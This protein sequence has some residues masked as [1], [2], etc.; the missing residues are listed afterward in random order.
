M[1]NAPFLTYISIARR[2]RYFWVLWFF[3]FPCPYF[4]GLA[5]VPMCTELSSPKDGDINILVNTPLEW[6][7]SPMATGYMI[8]IGSGPGA[9]DILDRLDVGN[10]VSYT[11]SDNLPK[12]KTLYATVLAYNSLGSAVGCTETSFHTLNSSKLSCTEIIN[13]LNGSI[14]V[15]VTANI[16]WIRDFYATGYLMTVAEKSIDGYR[17]LDNYEVGNGTNFKPPDFKPHTLYFVTVTPYNESQRAIGCIPISF[18]TGDAVEGLPCAVLYQPRNGDTNV[19]ISTNLR[20]NPVKVAD[21]YTLTV[22][23]SVG[24]ADIVD[25]LDLGLSSNYTFKEDL[26]E[27]TQ[28]F[29]SLEPYNANGTAVDCPTI[30]FFTEELIR[31]SIPPFFTPNNDGFNDRWKPMVDLGPAIAQTLIFDRYGKLLKQLMGDEEWDGTYNQ[32]AQPS[33]SYW[34]RINFS[35]GKILN[36]YFLLKR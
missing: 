36:G 33:S 25:N 6:N 26:P 13:P 10:V 24:G 15:S 30:S 35:N 20:W 29:V 2:N 23:T 28:V 22:G 12:G 3:W 14:Y 31:V 4:I 11:L 32:I 8:T 21:G 34:Y 1:D 9:S 5:Q 17:V 18:T 27:N 7:A 19:P 16:T